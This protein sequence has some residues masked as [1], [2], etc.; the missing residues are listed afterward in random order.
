[1][2]VILR[3]G[4]FRGRRH[5]RRAAGVLDELVDA[6]VEL[7]PQLPESRR[8]NAAD[9]LA[10]LALLADTYRYYADGW[11]EREE[12]ERRGNDT[13]ERLSQL[14]DLQEPQHTELD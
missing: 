6:Q 14:R 5:A 2:I 11:I 7:L 3:M 8:A 12:L 9:Y 10:E 4:F 13:I 1:M